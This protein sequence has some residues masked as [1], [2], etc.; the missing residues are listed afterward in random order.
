LIGRIADFKDKIDDFNES[1]RRIFN[2]VGE[3]INKCF[4]CK[5]ASL[6]II[7]GMLSKYAIAM[8]GFLEV[9]DQIVSKLEVFFGGT[10]DKANEWLERIK[11]AHNDIKPSTLALRFCHSF[12]L[13][14]QAL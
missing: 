5:L 9:I 6:I 10:G 13:C 12:G 14:R 2:R 1:V 8:S 7:Y 11:K 3:I 4:A